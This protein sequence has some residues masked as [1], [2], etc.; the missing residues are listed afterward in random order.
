MKYEELTSQIIESA[1]KVHNL[2]G[3][4]FLENVYQNALIIELERTGVRA[5]KEKQVK[6]LYEG[7]IIGD[8]IA[9]IIVEDKVII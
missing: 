8:Y 2:L 9:D 4:G 5:E 1:Y 6:V 3:F 7:K